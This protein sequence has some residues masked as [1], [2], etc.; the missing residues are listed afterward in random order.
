M[1]GG[2]NMNKELY[3]SAIMKHER[4]IREI[5]D[6]PGFSTQDL[7]IMG[8]CLDNVKDALIILAMDSDTEKTY[9][10]SHYMYDDDTVYVKRRYPVDDRGYSEYDRMMNAK[11]H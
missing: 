8:K 3:R 5:V 1:K 4:E 7:D 2:G 6:K 10:D 9:S 11:D